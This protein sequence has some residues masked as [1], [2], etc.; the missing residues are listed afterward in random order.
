[1]IR[2]FY[3]PRREG[4]GLPVWRKLHGQSVG[5]ASIEVNRKTHEF[6]ITVTYGLRRKIPTESKSR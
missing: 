5:P 6:L 1:M 4:H 3:A 2:A